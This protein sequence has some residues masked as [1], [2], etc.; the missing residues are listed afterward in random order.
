MQ[1]T[2]CSLCASASPRESLAETD[3]N[4]RLDAIA[5]DALQVIPEKINQCTLIS[6]RVSN[7]VTG[8]TGDY[9]DANTAAEFPPSPS[10]NAGH[11]NPLME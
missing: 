3:D 1:E 7:T 9:G 5:T 2:S 11:S 8:T 4:M 10:Q 6:P